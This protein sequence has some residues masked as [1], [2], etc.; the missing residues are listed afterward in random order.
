[1]WRWIKLDE[2]MPAKCSAESRF[3]FD[4]PAPKQATPALLTLPLPSLSPY[5]GL[6]RLRPKQDSDSWAAVPTSL[7]QGAPGP[8]N[9]TLVDDLTGSFTGWSWTYSVHGMVCPAF[10]PDRGA[11]KGEIADGGKAR[12]GKVGLP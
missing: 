3:P 5:Q 2:M 6:A 9:V 4:A 1:V 12:Q 8:G 11:D 10:S 7:H